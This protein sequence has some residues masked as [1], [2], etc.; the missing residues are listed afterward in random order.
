M[1]F[2]ALLDANVLYPIWLC[3]VLLTAAQ[4]GVFQ[5]RWSEG[6]LEEAER[7]VKQNR[8]SADAPAISRR[9]ENMRGNFKEAMVTGFEALEP[10]M[11]NDPKDR[12]VLAA[13]LV[14]RADVIVTVN[15]SDFPEET[16]EPYDIDAQ[17]PDEFLC[18]QWELDEELMINAIEDRLE[19]YRNPPQSL[20]TV[21]Q[22]L[23]LHTPRFVAMV[24]ESGESVGD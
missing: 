1:P 21:L 5:V 8:P 20:D 7:N 14:G 19:D 23:D 9:F 16:R 10:C 2:V 3:D 18:N 13:A 11:T 17:H 6:I 4:T 15:L 22:K 24:R 12:H